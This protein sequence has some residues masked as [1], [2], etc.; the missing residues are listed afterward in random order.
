ML[1]V[2]PEKKRKIKKYI[3][4]IWDIKVEGEI[5]SSYWILDEVFLMAA[6]MAYGSS[7]A[8]DWIQARA[9]TY[10]AAVVMLGPFI[11]LHQAGDQTWAATASQA[12]AVQFLTHCATAGTPEYYMFIISKIF[13]IIFFFILQIFLLY[14]KNWLIPNCVSVEPW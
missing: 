11:L 6:P 8:K 9:V 7:W 10:I 2:R 4:I 3:L 14:F 12:N 13:E 1:Q 5:L